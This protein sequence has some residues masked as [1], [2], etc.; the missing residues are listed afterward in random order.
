MSISTRAATAAVLASAAAREVRAASHGKITNARPMPIGQL[1]TRRAN[2]VPISR[3]T[4]QS[5]VILVNNTLSST[6]PTP[7]I[8]RPV[9]TVG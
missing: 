1:L 4:N 9:S 8:K 6:A 2:A 5:V 7:L 3:P